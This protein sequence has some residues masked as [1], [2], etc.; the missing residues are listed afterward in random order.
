MAA[1]RLTGTAALGEHATSCMPE[2]FADVGHCVDAVFRRVGARVVLAMPLGIGNP[3]PL[4]NGFYRRACRDPKID[5]ARPASSLPWTR[6]PRCLTSFRLRLSDLTYN[7]R[8]HSLA[9]VI[10]TLRKPSF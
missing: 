8:P 2:T 5:L 7:P 3:N 9:R 4:A 10:L 6:S 1:P